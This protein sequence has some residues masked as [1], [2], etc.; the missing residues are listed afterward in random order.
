M[1][2]VCTVQNITITDATDATNQNFLNCNK[3]WINGKQET[4]NMIKNMKSL[5][6]EKQRLQSEGVRKDHQMFLYKQ[7]IESLQA[8]NTAI[9][10]GAAEK[11]C[12]NACSKKSKVENN[13]KA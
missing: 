9:Q 10:N 5:F 7:Q 1:Y 4:V 2:K 6:L 13:K 11:L 8:Q 12:Y 3:K